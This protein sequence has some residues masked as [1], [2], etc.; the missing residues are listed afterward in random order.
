MNFIRCNTIRKE[1]VRVH[2]KHT[3]LKY[4]EFSGIQYLIRSLPPWTV[5]MC[6]TMLEFVTFDIIHSS[7][8][9]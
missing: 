5:W 7:N 1:D 6:S 3:N 9:R 2:T 4:L 8:T